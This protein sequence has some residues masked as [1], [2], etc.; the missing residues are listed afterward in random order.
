MLDGCPEM[1]ND[2]SIH[3]GCTLL[4]DIRYIFLLVFSLGSQYLDFILK[5]RFI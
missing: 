4:E 2:R 1:V 3:P 5:W